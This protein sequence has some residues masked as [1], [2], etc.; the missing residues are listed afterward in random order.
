VLAVIAASGVVTGAGRA[1]HAQRCPRMDAGASA[2]LED[3]DGRVRL[4]WI[5]ARLMRQRERALIWSWTW[6]STFA[7]AGVASLIALPLD[8]KDARVDWYVSAFSAAVGVIPFVAAP[9]AVMKDAK[10]LHARLATD[11]RD[12]Q[13]CALLADAETRLVRDARDEAF[14]Q[15]WWIHA[16]NVAFNTG[17]FLFLGVGFHRWESAIINGA[18]GLVVGEAMILTQPTGSIDD[19]GN[20]RAGKL[21]GGN[22]SISGRWNIGR[23]LVLHF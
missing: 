14:G 23:G 7:A 6:G 8:S 20:Y 3:V 1:A 10:D 4:H 13:V 18:A 16:G 9:L 19:L 2:Q 11:V 5:D 21:W 15:G 12:D 17:V 22:F